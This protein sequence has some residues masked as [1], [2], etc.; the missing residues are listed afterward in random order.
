EEPVILIAAVHAETRGI[1]RQI[2]ERAGLT[3]A[4]V[5]NGRRALDWLVGNPAPALILLDQP[6]P[7]FD[8]TEF[9]IRLRAHAKLR[10][11]PV[12][13]LPNKTPVTNQLLPNDRIALTLSKG[14]LAE[15]LRRG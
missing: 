10:Q 8:G 14:V 7:D 4:E 2:I 12:V 3:A 9:L 15:T 1:A 5:A 6:M 11:I 13:L